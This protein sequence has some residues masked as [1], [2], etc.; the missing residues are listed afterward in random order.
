MLNRK[1]K[2]LHKMNITYKETEVLKSCNTTT[3]IL[4]NDRK[5]VLLANMS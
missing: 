1:I 5:E 3:A 4:N 2:T